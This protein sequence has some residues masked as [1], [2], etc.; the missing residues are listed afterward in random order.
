MNRKILDISK[1]AEEAQFSPIRKFVPFLEKAKKRGVEVFELHIGQPDL[2]TP[3]EILREIKNFKGKILSYT[4]SIGIE[5]VRK[6]WQ[7]YYKDV[8][9][10][11]DTSEIIVTTGG[12][13]AIFFAFATICNPGQEIIVFEPFYTNYNGYASIAGIKLVPVRT[14]AKNGFHLP[15]QKEI[16]K[17]INKKT[18]GIL[19][20]N[21]NNP[22]GTVYK[23][24]ELKMLAEIAKKRDLFILSDEV[25]REFVYDG[26]KH[27]SM[28]DFPE[29]QDRVILLDSVSKR[30]SACG[31]RIGCLASKNKKVIEGATKFAQARL[32]SPMVEQSAVIPL[33]KNSKKYTQKIVREYKRRRDTVFEALQKIPGI[34]CLKPKGA[35]YI[36]VKLPI[37]PRSRDASLRGKDSDDF[38][39]WLLTKF[40]FRGKTVMVASASGFYA[41]KGLGK[42]EIRI[43]FVLCSPKLKEAMEVFKKGLE[44]YIKI[45]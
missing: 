25:Y 15:S 29:I 45:N 5:E 17:K 31:A 16:E 21:P 6:A 18:R 37:K 2:E 24:E 7:K 40:S 38:A 35:F 13:E 28:M 22:T 42:D 20:C 33:L 34:F 23:K 27:Y 9:I 10:N 1:R 4:N 43:A 30:F 36:I 11:L 14:F 3:K 26:E 44:Q 12:S 19:I 39:K 32:S 8:G 41:T